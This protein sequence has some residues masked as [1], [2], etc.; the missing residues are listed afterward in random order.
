MSMVTQQELTA[1]SDAGID[2]M[3]RKLNP[4]DPFTAIIKRS[5]GSS[6]F[7]TRL[8]EAYFTAV[9]KGTFTSDDLPHGA[10]RMEYIVCNHCNHNIPIEYNYGDRVNGAVLRTLA[11]N[12]I[13]RRVG[14]Q[15][16][17]RGAINHGR[18][19]ESWQFNPDWYN[20]KAQGS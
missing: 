17:S 6:E 4:C 16:S 1:F 5:R 8:L 11:A 3:L 14:T 9:E 2:Y 15:K 20:I 18:P 13:I 10:S 7:K 19:I 12:G